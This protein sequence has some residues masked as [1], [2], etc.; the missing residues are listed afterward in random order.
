LRVAQRLA[1]SVRRRLFPSEWF[2]H[3]DNIQAYSG[4][5]SMVVVAKEV[6]DTYTDKQTLL[7]YCEGFVEGADV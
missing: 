6:W 2:D 4:H 5:T 1:D 3:L 7:A